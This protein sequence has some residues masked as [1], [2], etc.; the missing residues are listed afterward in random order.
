MV[1]SFWFFINAT[2]FHKAILSIRL[3][4]TNFWV[5]M[6][7]SFASYLAATIGWKY[8]LGRSCDSLPV[9][10]LFKIRH[11]GEMVSL[12][13]PIG[14]IG[15]EAVKISLLKNKGI[16]EKKVVASIV[17]SR[18][19][20]AISQLLLFIIVTVAIVFN[21]TGMEV[22]VNH[23]LTSIVVIPALIVLLYVF[24]CT[25]IKTIRP[26]AAAP[27]ANSRIE[28][29][30]QNY[31]LKWKLV[32]Q[33][34]IRFYRQDKKMLAWAITFFTIHWLIGSMEF[35]FLLKFL[36]IH[37]TFQQSMFM[38]MGVVLFKSAGTL[39]P[40]QLGIEEYGNKIMLGLVGVP[41]IEI[42]ITIS[43]LR[44]LR[45]LIWIVVG[46]AFYLLLPIKYQKVIPT[47]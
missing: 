35:Y 41:G 1:I 33:E 32:R 40:A 37:I 14:I 13:N 3:V 10:Q 12:I 46:L 45:Q 22:S 44:R 8:C 17:I 42:W 26:L 2:E 43:I 7:V 18:V 9:L 28:K 24:L 6:L 39:I 38:D 34:I 20:M 19:L 29:L 15:G 27:R 4:G 11:I 25:N 30:V 47:T 31:W 21:R 36:G 5:P 23:L 16:E